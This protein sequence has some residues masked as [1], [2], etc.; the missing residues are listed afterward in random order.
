MSF[1][2]STSGVYIYIYTYVYFY[3]VVRVV[4]VNNNKYCKQVML[5]FLFNYINCCMYY[6]MKR[7]L[8]VSVNRGCLDIQGEVLDISNK[9]LIESFSSLLSK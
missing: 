7:H 3:F 6:V 9:T 4:C 5:T 8:I 2:Y 1:A